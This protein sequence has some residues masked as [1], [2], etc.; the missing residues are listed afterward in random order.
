MAAR[1]VAVR[2]LQMA[3]TVPDALTEL[4]VRFLDSFLPLF[5]V[6]AE[7]PR[8]E[9]DTVRVGTLPRLVDHLTR[10]DVDVIHVSSHGGKRY[11]Q[12]ESRD[13]KLRD[14][15]AAMRGR[16]PIDAIVLSTACEMATPKWVDAWLEAGATAFIGAKRA[17]WAKDAAIFSAA[18]SSALFGTTHRGKSD[19]QRAFDAYRVAHAAC[20]S[21]VPTGSRAQ[22]YWHPNDELRR[23][24]KGRKTLAPI[25]P[26]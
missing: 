23:A 8:A 13:L 18:F 5:D 20:E 14:F 1:H 3:G 19:A 24:A 22:F 4:E 10:G 16:D 15:R 25:T 6:E 2:I 26:A 17:L 12:L 11:V 9:V 21:F 7:V